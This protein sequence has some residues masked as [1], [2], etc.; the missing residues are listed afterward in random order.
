MGWVECGRFLPEVPMT[1]LFA[2]LDQGEAWLRGTGRG[3]WRAGL[4]LQ[5]AK[6]LDELGRLQEAV[7]FAEE[8]LALEER[9]PNAPGFTLATYRWSLGDLLRKVGRVEDAEVQYGRV[10]DAPAGSV[11]SRFSGLEGLARCALDRGAL[12]EAQAHAA[13]AVREAEG[14]GS[15][16]LCSALHCL[17]AAHRRAGDRAAARAAATRHLGLARSLGTSDL[18]YAVRDA[19]DVALDDGDRSEAETLLAELEPYARALDESR[20]VTTFASALAQQRQRLPT[21]AP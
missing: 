2:V 12:V 4:C 13:G 3:G 8:A 17:V 7:G 10:L 9:Q 18:Y 11:H 16:I 6:V 21:A 14:L 19:A 1:G 20:G 5:R 15:N